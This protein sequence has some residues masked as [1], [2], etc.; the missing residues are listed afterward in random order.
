MIV[1]K[2][3]AEI[4]AQEMLQKVVELEVN[5]FVSHDKDGAKRMRETAQNIGMFYGHLRDAYLANE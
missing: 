1:D 5:M 4:F 2:D 3:R